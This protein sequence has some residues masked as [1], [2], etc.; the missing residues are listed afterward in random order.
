[1]KRVPD[2][3]AAPVGFFDSGVGGKCILSAFR[4]LCPQENLVYIADSVNCPYGSKPQEEITRL[5]EANVEELLK[6]KCKLIVI[7]CNTATAAAIDHLRGKYRDVPFVGIEPA[8][9]PA[10][11]NSKS[12]VVAV[13]ATEGTFNGRLYR[14]T[15]AKFAAGVTVIAAVADEFVTL[16][17]RGETEGPR[18]ESAVSRRIEPLLSAGADHIVLGCTHFPHLKKTMEKVI[19]GRAVIVDPSVA[20]AMQAKRVLAAEGLSAAGIRENGAVVRDIVH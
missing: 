19:G 1:M 12:A 16:V 13:L 17:E 5:C 11:L 9:K 8:V 14:E 20:V 3:K 18:A 15:V 10:A 2:A 7:A 4:R 6:R